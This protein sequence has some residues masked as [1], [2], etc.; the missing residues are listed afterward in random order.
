MRCER[1]LLGFLA[2]LG[3]VACEPEDDYYQTIDYNLVGNVLSDNSDNFNL[4]LFSTLLRQSGMSATLR[5]PGPYTVLA[6]ADLSFYYYGGYTEV[7]HILTMP[8]Q[9][10]SDL[11]NYHVI[12]GLYEFDK[13]PFLFN[14]EVRTH[15]GK[16]LYVTRW[17]D[18]NTG[19]T[20]LT[21]NGAQVSSRNIPASNGMINIID[22]VLVPNVHD[23]LAKAIADDNS[24]TLFN[25]AIYKA[26]LENLLTGT[27]PYT[28]FAPSN[29]AMAAYGFSSIQAVDATDP[30]ELAALV[31]Y[32]IL[33]DRRFINDYV[34]TIPQE[35]GVM[36]AY[37][38]IPF[39]GVYE[40]Q[41]VAGLVGEQYA[42]MADGNTVTFVIGVYNDPWYGSG[43][44]F[45]LVDITGN[46]VHA[47]RNDIIAGNGVLHV[48]DG[49]M[50]GA[51]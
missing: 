18:I 42:R 29:A 3:I 12:D 36:M 6:P 14:H 49:V 34:L 48:T 35:Q 1:L 17:L 47:V 22:K 51:Y 40:W 45:D 15:S 20:V 26:G 16:P 44:V 46:R 21:I 24:L 8:K 4:T 50:R 28:V 31:R 43:S 13:L 19:D 11:A 27:G 32:H 30:S 2:V 5:E 38:P 39:I 10:M 7:S 23:N 37:V 9:T 41:P 33:E 25:H